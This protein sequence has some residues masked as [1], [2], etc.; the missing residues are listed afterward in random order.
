MKI[1]FT[2]DTHF[3]HANIIE[4]CQRP[5]KDVNHMNH[6]MVNNWNSVVS[7]EDRVYHVGDFAMGNKSHWER[8]CKALNGCKI[9]IRGNH[10]KGNTFMLS[11]GFA[12]VYE[13]LMY[14]DPADPWKLV[15]DPEGQTGKIL[16]GHVHTSWRRK[17]TP[18]LDAINVGVDQW[19]FRPVS[20]EELMTAKSEVMQ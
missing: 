16:C 12:E 11:I 3:N 9:L 4:Y 2:S 8:F 10:D 15:H 14:G 17:M 13:T 1:W 20:F 6:A 5:F 7:P 19:G 18:E